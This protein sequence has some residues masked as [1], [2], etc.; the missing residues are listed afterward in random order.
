MLN[1]LL[2]ITLLLFS[3]TEINAKPNPYKLNK[4]KK[5]IRRSDYVEAA[6]IY[7]TY[8]TNKPDDQYAQVEYASILYF[9]L[10]DYE[11]ANPY[12][13][14]ALSN[15][16]D[17]L[18]FGLALLKTEIY[19]GHNDIASDLIIK[20]EKYS[21][22]NPKNIEFKNELQYDIKILDYQKTHP[23]LLKTNNFFVINAGKEVN[24]LYADYVSMTDLNEQFI[25]LTSRRK[26]KQKEKVIDI[27]NAYKEKMFSSSR[28][29]NRFDTAYTVHYEFNGIKSKKTFTNESFVSLSPDGNSLYLFK[30]GTIWKTNQQNQKWEKPEKFEK[31]ILDADY[32]NHGTITADGKHFYFSSEKEGG[33]GGLD[34]YHISKNDDGSWT[35]VEAL[36]ALNTKGNEQG[37]YITK[38]GKTIYFS[39]DSLDGFGGYDIFK[40]EFDGKSWSSP[41][42]LGMPY[43]SVA[44]DIF[45]IPKEKD[46]VGYL[47]SNRQGTNGNYDVYRFYSFNNSDFNNKNLLT[48]T[49]EKDTTFTVNVNAVSK[50]INKEIG[51]EA[52]NLFFNLN[53]SVEY[54]SIGELNNAINKITTK[55]I[56][57]EQQLICND[58]PFKNVNF[59]TIYHKDEVKQDTTSS[60]VSNSNTNNSATANNIANNS[61]TSNIA[62]T[63]Q[64]INFKF[65]QC[66]PD[67]S[68]LNSIIELIKQGNKDNVKILLEGHTDNVGSE[69]YNQKLSEKRAKAV[70]S[71]L[72]KQKVISSNSIEIKGL[73]E[74]KPK[75][76]CKNNCSTEEHSKNRRVEIKFIPSK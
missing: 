18:S 23:S 19:L 6:K 33:K 50:Y 62:E 61:S 47:S 14:K 72:V 3:F 11:K 46:E 27:E 35:Q 2:N 69:E 29:L 49:T 10:K 36:N 34:I 25:L 56:E 59:F 67:A 57:I 55:K 41:V 30:E 58:C 20:L 64:T 17:T 12:I 60:L 65:N 13:Q 22:N 66:T 4:A 48:I 71:E 40:S 16:T 63:S 76:D 32:T 1:L 45:F 7:E 26:T 73:G 68:T 37:P 51:F 52:S 9:D 39:S 53:D 43:N 70:K 38:D 24:S 42:N 31:Q 21:K 54:K 8:L 44:D 75:I 5:H 15:S 28:K 74:S